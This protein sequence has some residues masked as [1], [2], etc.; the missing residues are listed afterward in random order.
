[1]IHMITQPASVHRLA[2]GM[3]L[4][5]LMV[6]AAGCGGGGSSSAPTPVASNQPPAITVVR[7]LTVPAGE[8][9]S[10]SLQL[11]DDR[12]PAA[13][14]AVTV[15]SSNPELLAN[16]NISVTGTGGT[17]VLNF[18]PTEDNLGTSNLSITASDA[19]NAST[20]IALR[21]EV[22]ARHRPLDTFIR[23]EFVREA[24]GNPALINALD[25]AENPGVDDYNDLLSP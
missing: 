8:P 5:V 18:T 13:N 2:G 4:S 23:S 24:D 3:V 6:L 15:T 11:V 20:T 12:T 9:G 22:V 7:D 1:M 17:R 25:L 10:T 14:L 19:E 16:R 21:L